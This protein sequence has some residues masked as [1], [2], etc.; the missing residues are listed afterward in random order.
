MH[1]RKVAFA[2]CASYPAPIP[3]NFSKLDP[4]EPRYDLIKQIRCCPRA[5]QYSRIE[6]RFTSLPQI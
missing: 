6:S 4:T 1:D 5:G 3:Q 2:P